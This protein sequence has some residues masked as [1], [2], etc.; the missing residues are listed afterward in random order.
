MSFF[1]F[2]PLRPPQQSSKRPTGFGPPPD[3]FA[4][5]TGTEL[6]GDDEEDALDYGETHDELGDRLDESGDALNDATFGG[7]GPVGK[8]F[9]FGGPKT[10][11]SQAKRQTQPMQQAKQQH[12]PPPMSQTQRR[13]QQTQMPELS[14]LPKLESKPT[15]TGYE[16]YKTQDGS[17]PDLQASASIWQQQASSSQP[18]QRAQQVQPPSLATA[19]KKMMSLEEV[20]AAMRVQR[21][22]P[23]QSTTPQP[24]P[25]QTAPAAHP[26]V[27]KQPPNLGHTMQTAGQQSPQILSTPAQPRV[28]NQLSSR[29]PIPPNQ[30]QPVPV[31]H[32]SQGEQTPS[33]HN[34]EAQM[35]AQQPSP[36]ITQPRPIVQTGAPEPAHIR[37]VSNVPAN[38]PPLPSGGLHSRGPSGMIPPEQ[39]M[40]L[41][42]EE[43]AAVLR[44][45]AI[46]AKR[47]H[48]ILLLSKDNGIMTPQDKNFITR[49]QLQQLVTATGGVDNNGPETSLVEDFY[50]QVYSQIR[51]APKHGDQLAQTYLNQL[52]WRGGN[53]R[54]PRG[55]ESHMR[56]MEQ[57]VQRAV[58]RAK[59]KPKSQQLVVEGSLGKISFSNAKTPKPLLNIRRT[60]SHDVNGLNVGRGKPQD[61]VAGLKAILRN[62]EALYGTL[63]KME[64]HERRMPPPPNEES[65]GDEMQN[66]ITWRQRI[67]ELNK[68]LWKQLKVLE[69]L[70][71]SSG[72]THP[73]IAI[74]SHTKGK[75]LAPRI[76]R[77]I[78]DQQRLT[79]L[80][81]IVIQLDML[82]VIRFA[83]PSRAPNGLPKA[84]KESIEL[85]TQAVMPS[86][87]A[88]INDATLSTVIGL[89]GLVTERV[90][91]EAV[92]QTKSGIDFL[93]ML[94]SRAEILKQGHVNEA[95]RGQWLQ[96]YDHFFDLLQPLFAHMFLGASL[97][98]DD[99]YA[100]QFLAALGIGASP[101]QQQRLVLAVKDKVM[102]TVGQAKALPEVQGKPMLDKVNLFMRAIGLDV[103]LLG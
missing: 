5:L 46:R 96:A 20:E 95:D 59:A 62:V 25:Q 77:Q 88:Y 37:S 26:N 27:V 10:S 91:L 70:D 31:P 33:M 78:D 48:K 52:S 38:A 82:D 18:Q 101:D 36:H 75:K 49:I 7:S 87:F 47:N 1:D 22:Q 80:T 97:S 3:P 89:V 43:R 69:P 23:S 4:G 54:Y 86:L 66:H 68:T 79:V 102:E 34:L 67:Q 39:L 81:M 35:R 94:L 8:D 53:R 63:M 19:T 64:D 85:F 44:D 28:N 41:S 15:K 99:K 57:Q 65:S 100:W 51:G 71:P 84:V 32:Q 50:Y 12:V 17:I 76:F 42:E 58:D 83:Q 73:F 40:H 2:D 24:G 14:G 29:G 103:D 72:T 60:E 45:E 90:N 92:V 9:N 16:K 55:G 13:P 98:N 56:R 61:A 93:T 74:I 11:G 21:K 6:G 30:M